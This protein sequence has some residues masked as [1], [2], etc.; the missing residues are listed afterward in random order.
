MATTPVNIA[1]TGNLTNLPRVGDLTVAIRN[2]GNM[3]PIKTAE[4]FDRTDSAIQILAN[5]LAGISGS[6]VVPTDTG[7]ITFNSAPVIY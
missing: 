4:A 6:V 3:L 7:G 1:L 5:S 2:G